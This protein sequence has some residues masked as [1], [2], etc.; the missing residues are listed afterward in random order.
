RALRLMHEVSPGYLRHFTAY[1]DTLGGLEALRAQ[2]ASAKADA[3]AAPRARR[4]KPRRGRGTRG[5]PANPDYDRGAAAPE[6]SAAAG[7][8]ASEG[9]TPSA[10]ASVPAGTAPPSGAAGAVAGPPTRDTRQMM[11]AR[12]SA[13]ITAPRGSTV[14]PTGRPRVVPSSSR[15]PVAK[16]I[17]S[18]AGRPLRNGT[19]T[20]L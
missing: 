11:L 18:P 9:A 13:M 15:K 20:T 14:T 4:G 12:S 1:V 16:S 5:S 6:A 17:G 7:V 2:E 8:A 19:N 10:G 3:G